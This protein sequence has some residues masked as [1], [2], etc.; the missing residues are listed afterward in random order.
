[1]SNYVDIYKFHHLTRPTV[2]QCQATSKYKVVGI[3]YR[4]RV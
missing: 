1:M 4:Y 2:L 3:R